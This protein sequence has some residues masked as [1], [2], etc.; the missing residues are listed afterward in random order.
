MHVSARVDAAKQRVV[1]AALAAERA[2]GA[3]AADQ[4]VA[5]AKNAAVLIASIV[6]LLAEVQ[7]A[8]NAEGEG[9]GEE[10]AATAALASLLPMR[11]R[12][13]QIGQALSAAV[14][15]A[16]LPEAPWRG[17]EGRCPAS[18]SGAHQPGLPRGRR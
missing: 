11:E 3:A 4:T 8:P 9:E 5:S 14:P 18:A 12:L 10:S 13:E 2:R 17:S 15:A 16:P 7:R 6:D 1:A